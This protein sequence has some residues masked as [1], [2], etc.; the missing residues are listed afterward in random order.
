MH[1]CKIEQALEMLAE[2]ALYSSTDIDFFCRC[3]NGHWY[4]K[5]H[6]CKIEQALEMLVDTALYSMTDYRYI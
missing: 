5:V 3:V 6:V 2:T 1:V 4:L